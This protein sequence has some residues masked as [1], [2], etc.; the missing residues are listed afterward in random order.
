MSKIYILN[1]TLDNEW[2][3]LVLSSNPGCKAA[4]TVCPEDPL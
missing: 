3:Q 4:I 1:Y 2:Y